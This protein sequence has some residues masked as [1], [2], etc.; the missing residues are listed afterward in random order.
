M[1]RIST[2]KVKTL[3]EF[4][5]RVE[6]VSHAWAG[7]KITT[8]PWFRGQT[9]AGWRLIPGLYRSRV[10]GYWERELVRDFRLH[11]HLLLQRTPNNYL[12]WLFLMQ[13]YGMPT[14]LLDWTE[15]Y[16]SALFFAVMD[17]GSTADGAVWTLDPWSLNEHSIVMWSVP[18]ADNA[19]LAPYA[20]A[21][22]ADGLGRHIEAKYPVAVRP[23]RSNPRIN[24]QRGSFTVH[25]SIAQALDTVARGV[26]RRR[27]GNRILLHKIVVAG[28]HKKQIRKDLYLAGVTEAVLFPDLSGL[29]GEISY[30][31]S[32]EY[33]GEL[34]KGSAGEEYPAAPRSAKKRG[35]L[36]I[37][38]LTAGDG[39]RATGRS[40]VTSAFP[41]V[42]V[43][44]TD[45]KDFDDWPGSGRAP[46]GSRKRRSR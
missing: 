43:F 14:R 34:E 4:I 30:R 11:S 31:Y 12:E 20:L 7:L 25:G 18:T 10:G 32:D 13:H 27:A 35:Q 15:S 21:A 22:G 45:A 41:A 17:R 24:A 16:L 40:A 9:N 36:M 19:L 28:A 6:E 1:R 33:V 23:P 37:L 39:R 42:N 3:A 44:G 29:C 5:S 26:N 2:K 46:E 8:Q 38:D